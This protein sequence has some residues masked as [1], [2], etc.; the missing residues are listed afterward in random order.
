[1][2]ESHLLIH[3]IH[4]NAC[5]TVPPGHGK[6]ST[7][8]RNARRR[9]K[10]LY[11]KEKSQVE[12]LASKALS[13]GSANATPLGV[14]Q[15]NPTITDSSTS[16]DTTVTL[17]QDAQVVSEHPDNFVAEVVP[18]FDANLASTLRNKNKKKGFK[19]SMTGLV[20]SKIV[21]EDATPGSQSTP[22]DSIPPRLVTPSEK[23]ELGL[24][25]SNM[26]VTSVEVEREKRTKKRKKAQ[27]SQNYGADLGNDWADNDQ[28]LNE[29]P[30]T[31]SILLDY[32]DPDSESRSHVGLEMGITKPGKSHSLRKY[33]CWIQIEKTWESSTPICDIAMLKNGSVI[34]WKVREI[35]LS[36]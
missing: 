5:Y 13:N 12:L 17:H 21:F 30:R 26:F 27:D 19:R 32:G 36:R 11:E 15:S 31:D 18:A 1:M 24:L 16:C 14:R 20:P 35:V 2:V 28:Y 7:R 4:R 10:R 34:G 9:L 23:Q 33:K 25:P 8:N 29:I 22:V 6:Q 3:R